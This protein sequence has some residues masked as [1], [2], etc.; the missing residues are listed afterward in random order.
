M[1]CSKTKLTYPNNT[2]RLMPIWEDPPAPPK[3]PSSKALKKA[4]ATL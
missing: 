1:W 2:M 3:I 4:T